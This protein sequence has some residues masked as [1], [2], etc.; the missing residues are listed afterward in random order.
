MSG[1]PS[2][3]GRNAFGPEFENATPIRNPKQNVGAEFMNLASWQLAGAGLVIPRALV[4]CRVSGAAITVSWQNLSWD[5]KGE[6]A[7]ITAV[8]LGAGDYRLEFAANYADETGVPVPFDLVGGKPI[9]DTD[10]N[11]NGVGKRLNA[12]QI[13]MRI[14]TANTGAA[15][16]SDFLA[17]VW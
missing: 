13:R 9:P 10:S 16:D 12:T 4:K 7:L 14:F 2:R 5:P 15:V 6:L 17:L 8:Y 1:F 11:L 3:P